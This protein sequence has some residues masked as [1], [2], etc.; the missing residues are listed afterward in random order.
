MNAALPCVGFWLDRRLSKS[1]SLLVLPQSIVFTYD[2]IVAIMPG[3]E[4]KQS[5]AGKTYASANSDLH[6]LLCGLGDSDIL[7]LG[8]QFK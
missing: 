8:G 7:G 5:P 1:S 4:I 6:L 3:R 2:R